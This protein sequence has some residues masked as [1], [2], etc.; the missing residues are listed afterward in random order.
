MDISAQATLL[1]DRP[2]QAVR[3]TSFACARKTVGAASHRFGFAFSE[4]DA[5]LQLM[6]IAY[7]L[8]LAT[9]GRQS[10]RD[11]TGSTR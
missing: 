5:Y 11:R 7:E 10:R 2:Q 6:R 9:A 3:V 8:C 4:I 1:A